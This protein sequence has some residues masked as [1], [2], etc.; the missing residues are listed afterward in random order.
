MDTM[1][2]ACT[3]CSYMIKHI[4]GLGWSHPHT[5]TEG[6][7]E[8]APEPAPGPALFSTEIPVVLQGQLCNSQDYASIWVGFCNNMLRADGTRRHTTY[9]ITTLA[10]GLLK[11]YKS[12]FTTE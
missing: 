4:D 12:R 9:S 10:D 6:S 7:T 1:P 5:P 3:T 11:A 8:P 2:D